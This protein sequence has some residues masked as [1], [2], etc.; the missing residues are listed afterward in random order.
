MDTAKGRDAEIDQI[1][2]RMLFLNMA[3]I[4]TSAEAV[5]NTILDLCARPQD[6][7]VLRQEMLESLK[8]HDGLRLATLSDLKKTDSFI[9]ESSRLNTPGLSMFQRTLS[10]HA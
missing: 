8:K 3:A 10:R 1:V 9:K 4:H 7:A 6:M 5:T 2:K